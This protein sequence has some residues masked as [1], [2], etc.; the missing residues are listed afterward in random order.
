MFHYDTAHANRFDLYQ[1]HMPQL[2]SYIHCELGGGHHLF[3]GH[4]GRYAQQT[5]HTL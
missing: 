1:A 2:T 4:K 3:M 5:I